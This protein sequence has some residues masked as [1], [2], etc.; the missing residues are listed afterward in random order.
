MIDPMA[1]QA[2]RMCQGRGQGRARLLVPPWAESREGDR[3]AGRF[4]P[5]VRE[6]FFLFCKGDFSPYYEL[7][8]PT[9]KQLTPKEDPTQGIQLCI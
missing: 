4:G 9:I 2:H 7:F 5:R 3:S 1:P 8:K 6:G